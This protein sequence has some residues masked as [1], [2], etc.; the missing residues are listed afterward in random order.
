MSQN[1]RIALFGNSYA[2]KVQLPA[3]RHVGGNEVIGLAGKDLAKA[4]D[5]AERWGIPRATEDWTELLALEPDLVIVSTPVDL[6]HDMVRAALAAG[7]AVLCEKPFTLDVAQ[8]TELCELARGRLALVDHQLRWNPYRR[9]LRELVQSGFVGELFH[10][11]TDLVLDSPTFLARPHSWWFEAERGGGVLGALASH[12]VDNLL[13]TFGPI[14]AVRARLETFVRE[15]P[16][17]RGRPRAVTSDDHAELWLRAKSG[18]AISL[19]TSVVL[20]GTSRW[21]TEVSGSQGTL[22]LDLEDDLIGGRHGQ[23]MVAIE[24]SA[25]LPPP[26]I[27]G[28]GA[29]GAFAACEPLFLRDVIGALSRGESSVPEAATFEDGLACMRVLEAARESSQSGGWVD[30]G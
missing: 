27:Y 14:E 6:H 19:T 21:L 4:Q 7:A 9:K 18:A 10:V 3:L 26:E 8:A 22:R 11:R 17:A 12:L 23:A 2:A 30:C 28:I 15:R 29:G 5:T 16:D 24:P 13:W 1:V 20:P 25:A